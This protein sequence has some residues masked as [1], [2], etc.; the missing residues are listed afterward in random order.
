MVYTVTLN[1][2]LD[3]SV[4]LDEF[5]EGNTNRTTKEYLSI[6]G[7][8]INVSIVLKNLG[9]DSKALGFL[10]GF[11]GEYIKSELEKKGIK[12]D[13]IFTNSG[14]TRINVKL[15]TKIES[16]INANSQNI[17]DDEMKF[18]ME[19][20]KCIQDGDYLVLSGSIPKSLKNTTYEDIIKS[21]KNKDIKIIVDTTGQSLLKTLVYNPFLVKPNISEL[22]ELFD[23][24]INS[25][26][27]IE[28]YAKKILEKGA[29]NVIVSL[30]KDGAMFVNSDM[31]IKV[32]APKGIL[33]NSVGSG[34]SMVAGFIYGYL[35]N[36]YYEQAFKY[37]V[38]CGSATA[39]SDEL[40][41]K[42][43]V[44]KIFGYIK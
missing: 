5:V 28:I 8:G 30:G 44:E 22:E 31:C 2:S 19:K 27:E 15:K 11:T 16:E 12:N 36:S 41:T 43:E 40:A 4:F 39:F 1:P 10:S 23:T 17:S 9:V 21:L 14:I 32:A 6:G 38:S 25:D 35:L 7:K 29:K 33:K 37:A 18:F 24:K 34:D 42:K 26:E 3:Y 13:F 20:I